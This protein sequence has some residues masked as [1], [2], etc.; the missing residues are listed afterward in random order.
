MRRQNPLSCSQSNVL[1]YSLVFPRVPSVPCPS[2]LEEPPTLLLEL[3][4][5][6]WSR[7]IDFYLQCKMS[8]ES[9]SAEMLHLTCH[10]FIL[11]AEH[12][13]SHRQSGMWWIALP[14]AEGGQLLPFSTVT[15]CQIFALWEDIRLFTKETKGRSQDWSVLL[16]HLVH[17]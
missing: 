8:T 16:F 11:P 5:S 12:R 6:F 4:A 9:Y 13:C 10:G 1:N 14:K 17:T 7:S 15:S 2:F 3:V